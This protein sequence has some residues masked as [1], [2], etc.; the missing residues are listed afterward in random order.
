[1][2]ID[3]RYKYIKEIK[4]GSFEM[5]Y[6]GRFGYYEIVNSNNKVILHKF[7]SITPDYYLG[8]MSEI[9]VEQFGIIANSYFNSRGE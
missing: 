5:K 2:K 3:A 8:V 1:M 6:K 7:N 9:T 4:P